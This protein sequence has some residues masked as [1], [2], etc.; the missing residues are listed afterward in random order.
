MTSR[1]AK[2]QFRAVITLVGLLSVMLPSLGWFAHETLMAAEPATVRAQRRV[3]ALAD[4]CGVPAA[5]AFLDRAVRQPAFA[6]FGAGH[7][8]IKTGG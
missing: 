3:Q 4:E 1:Q 6:P 2:R 7:C 5:D 8:P